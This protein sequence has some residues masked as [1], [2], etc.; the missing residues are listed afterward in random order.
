MLPGAGPRREPGQEH[1]PAVSGPTP[2]P[3]VGTSAAWT[4]SA[5][6][7]TR[8]TTT[9]VDVS[10]S[11]AGAASPGNR[12][13]ARLSTRRRKAT[14]ERSLAAHRKSLSG[15][16]VHALVAVGQTILTEQIAS[17]AAHETVRQ[18]RGS[19][20]TRDVPGTPRRRPSPRTAG[21][22]GACLPALDQTLAVCHGGTKVS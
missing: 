20:R 12:A 3:S 11:L 8:P 13:C 10:R 18:E 17:R 21:P 19:S 15:R 14:R 6:P 2:R 7:T 22:Q 4:G 16:L 9:S 1:P 5:A